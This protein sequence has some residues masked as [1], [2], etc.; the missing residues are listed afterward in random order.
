M[1]TP[2]FPILTGAYN[3]TVTQIIA[4]YYAGGSSQAVMLLSLGLQQ[5]EDS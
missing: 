2:R 5:K 1:D 4:P 3:K